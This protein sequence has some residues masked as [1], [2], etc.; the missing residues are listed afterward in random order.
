[1]LLKALRKMSLVLVKLKNGQESSHEYIQQED[2]EKKEIARRNRHFIVNVQK[3]SE[4]YIHMYIPV[5]T[6]R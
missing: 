4:Y 3:G 2:A 1:M 6:S 5:H